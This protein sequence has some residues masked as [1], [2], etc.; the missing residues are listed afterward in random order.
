M[1]V[2]ALIKL[3]GVDQSS[4][5]LT[6]LSG[7]QVRGVQATPAIAP[8]GPYVGKAVY[9]ITIYGDSD[10]DAVS[11]VFFTGS[12]TATL[13]ETM[14]F[15][16]N[17]NVGNIV[18]PFVLTGVASVSSPPLASPFVGSALFHFTCSPTFLTL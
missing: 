10:G 13:V 2:S 1:A 18:T 12:A 5:T 8:F 3:S 14:V 7:T 9:Q 15:S 16:I 6:A 4:G 17:G 11:F